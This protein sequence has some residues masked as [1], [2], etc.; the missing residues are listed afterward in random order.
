[1]K[2][3]F[4]RKTPFKKKIQIFLHFGM[5]AARC[6]AGWSQTLKG[7]RNTNTQPNSEKFWI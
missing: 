7:H 4:A 5:P 6:R 1:M 3:T 2:S